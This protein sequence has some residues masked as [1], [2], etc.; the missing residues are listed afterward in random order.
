MLGY[1]I[2]AYDAVQPPID[3][4]NITIS[5]G[6]K[7]SLVTAYFITTSTASRS[8]FGKGRPYKMIKSFSTLIIVKGAKQR[9]LKMNKKKNNSAK[10]FQNWKQ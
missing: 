9:P 7:P 10:T 1:I 8:W 4:A 2:A 5:S 3:H 6:S